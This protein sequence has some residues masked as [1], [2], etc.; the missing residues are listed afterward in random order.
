VQ[1]PEAEAT[2]ASLEVGARADAVVATAL[3]RLSGACANANADRRKRPAKK[4]RF[5]HEAR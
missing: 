3:K 4:E 2:V 1:V 5:T